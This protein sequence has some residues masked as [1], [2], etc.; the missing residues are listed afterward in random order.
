MQIIRQSSLRLRAKG[1][2]CTVVPPSVF[3][4]RYLTPVNM[5]YNSLRDFA[6]YYYIST[7][8]YFLKAENKYKNFFLSSG[9]LRLNCAPGAL[10]MWR[11]LAAR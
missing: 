5:K 2:V 1:G 9:I 10:A 7:I 6:A 8:F 4:L 3:H 11:R